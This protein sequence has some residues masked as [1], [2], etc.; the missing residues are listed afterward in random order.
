MI[1]IVWVPV[2]DGVNDM[3]PVALPISNKLVLSEKVCVCPASSLTVTVHEYAV[4][5]AAVAAQAA[6]LTVGG[7]L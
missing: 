2:L 5:V 7:G 3:V 6:A 1:S 4:F